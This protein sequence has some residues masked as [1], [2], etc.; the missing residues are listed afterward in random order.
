MGIFDLKQWVRIGAMNRGAIPGSAGVSPA[1]SDF[2][3][4]TG[5][6]DA[7]A[8]RRFRGECTLIGWMAVPWNLSYNI[9]IS[10]DVI[11][12]QKN[13]I[14]SSTRWVWVIVNKL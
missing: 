6:R 5:R 11:F 8:P 3:F 12:R 2:R 9:N 10:A 13:I 4:A 14:A 7:G 1:S